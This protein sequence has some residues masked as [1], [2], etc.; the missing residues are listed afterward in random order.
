MSDRVDRCLCMTNSL[1]T[2]HFVLVIHFATSFSVN[3]TMAIIIPPKARNSIFV[4]REY[5]GFLLLE[6]KTKQ[7]VQL[8]KLCPFVDALVNPCKADLDGGKQET[9]FQ[10][11]KSSLGGDKNTISKH[12]PPCRCSRDPKRWQA[13]P[14]HSTN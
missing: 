9:T 13:L 8:G 5:P 2:F 1:K 12:K 11:R 14:R 4:S 7:I 10:K 6:R 3:D